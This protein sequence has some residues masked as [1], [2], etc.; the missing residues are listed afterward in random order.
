MAW[1]EWKPFDNKLLPVV[2]AFPWD[3]GETEVHLIYNI[4]GISQIDYE[5]HDNPDISSTYCTLDGKSRQLA[6][7]AGALNVAGGEVLKITALIRHPSVLLFK[8]TGY[9]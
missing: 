5:L 4:S 2:E 9:K 1:S 7:P 6:R 8:I 3:S